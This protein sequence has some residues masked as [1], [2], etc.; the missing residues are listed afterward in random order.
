MK[1]KTLAIVSTLLFLP[2][3]V[4]ASCGPEHSKSHPH[5]SPTGKNQ[6]DHSH[7]CQAADNKTNSC[8]KK[9][10]DKSAHHHDKDK[11]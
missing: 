11:H 8:V 5:N 1:F 9:G 10:V 3:A 7:H 2:F 6:K 4:N